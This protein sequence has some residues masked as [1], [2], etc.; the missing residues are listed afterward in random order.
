MQIDVS[1][2]YTNSPIQFTSFIPACR[3]VEVAVGD[4]SLVTR[5]GNKER[6]SSQWRK[7]NCAKENSSH[8]VHHRGYQVLFIYHSSPQIAPTLLPLLLCHSDPRH[9]SHPK[10]NHVAA[11]KNQPRGSLHAVCV[12][13]RWQPPSS[14][15]LSDHDI[16]PQKQDKDPPLGRS[17]RKCCTET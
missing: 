16:F 17:V 14:V 4:E 11:Q 10:P 7:H 15:E 8:L 1:L 3:S 9:I 5:A 2:G 13:V 6:R 12:R